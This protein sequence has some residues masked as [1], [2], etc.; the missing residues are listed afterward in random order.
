MRLGC[1]TVIIS[2]LLVLLISCVKDAPEVKESDVKAPIVDEA[3]VEEVEQE[4]VIPEETKSFNDYSID[5]IKKYSSTLEVLSQQEK[6]VVFLDALSSGD[7]ELVDYL[8]YGYGH[9]DIKDIKMTYEILSVEEAGEYDNCNAQVLLSIEESSSSA[10][11]EGEHIYNITSRYVADPCYITITKEGFDISDN[12]PKEKDEKLSDA[13]LFGD[14][15]LDFCFHVTKEKPDYNAIAELIRFELYEKLIVPNGGFTLS[16][17]R[18]YIKARFGGDDESYLEIEEEFAPYFNEEMG[19][20][21]YTYGQ[22]GNM[23]ARRV[24]EVV[25]TEKGYNVTYECFSDMSYLQKC[26][27]LTLV[28]EENENS[29]IMRLERID[30]NIITNVPMQ[31]YSP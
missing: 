20:Y 21:A 29:D 8:L 1:L 26:R 10:F 19:K 2:A 28:F 16:E 17:L 5:L 31:S 12:I 13:L 11:P 23:Q 7:V 4:E 22:C 24:S 15:Y 30:K 9:D 3:I 27:E 18:D 14:R 6:I 25:K